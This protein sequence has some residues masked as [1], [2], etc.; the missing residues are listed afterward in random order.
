MRKFGL[1]LAFLFVLGVFSFADEA[2]KAIGIWKSISDVKGEEGKV[3][4][5]WNLYL[6]NGVM[7]GVIVHAPGG[8]DSKIYDCKKKEFNGKQII[9]TPWITKMKKTGKDSWGGGTIVDVGNDKGD[10]YG[11]EIRI[12]KGGKVLEMRGFLG[13]SLLGRTQYWQASSE[14]ELNASLQADAAKK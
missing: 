8:D 1:C 11:C 14:D 6:T 3:T 7:E 9:N 5:F 10:V 4:G 2:D 12:T 13:I